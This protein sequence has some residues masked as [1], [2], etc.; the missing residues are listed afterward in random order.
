MTGWADLLAEA[1]QIRII[2]AR[3]SGLGSHEVPVWFALAGQDLAVLARSAE[4]DW[5]RN[6]R[7]EWNPQ[8]TVVRIVRIPKSL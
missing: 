5:V 8:A 3:R 6:A 7:A 1:R 2:T 4:G